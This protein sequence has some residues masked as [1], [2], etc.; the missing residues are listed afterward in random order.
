MGHESQC[1]S[2][3]DSPSQVG[4]SCTTLAFVAQM[5]VHV[6]D[7]NQLICVRR[8]GVIIFKKKFGRH[9]CM[10]PKRT[11][12]S[13]C[14]QFN[15]LI[16]ALPVYVVPCPSKLLPSFPNP[17]LFLSTRHM[18]YRGSFYCLVFLLSLPSLPCH[19]PTCQPS[20]PSSNR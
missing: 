16:A 2:T 10:Y 19:L 8:E 15:L 12:P 5:L 7:Q 9:T 1:C 3:V 6:K 20:K 11:V 17:L 18:R 13:F 14:S 4:N